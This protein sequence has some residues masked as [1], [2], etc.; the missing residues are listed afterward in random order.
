MITPPPG[1]VTI[2][3]PLARQVGYLAAHIEPLHAQNSLKVAAM[4][5]VD[6][7]L[8]GM[9]VIDD[10][11]Y[12]GFIMEADVTRALAVGMEETHPIR[13]LVIHKPAPLPARTPAAEALRIFAETKTEILAVVDTQDRVIG[14]LTP[15]RLISP[16]GH[17][18][19]PKRIGGL[20]TPIGVYLTDGSVSGGAPSYSLVLTGMA[21][22]G[23][24]TV[25]AYLAL[26]IG[27]LLP[28]EWQSHPLA[29][30]FVEGMGFVFFLL[31]IRSLPLAGYHAA[32]HMVVHAIEQGEPLE[33][34]AVRRMS[35]VHPRCG[36]NLAMA[37]MLFL[38]LFS[39]AWTTDTELRLLVAFLVTLVAYRPLGSFVQYWF[40][41][42][43]PNDK[44]LKSGIDAG[45][46]LLNNF[47][48]GGALQPN[49]LQRLLRT[50][51]FH[52]MAGST[53]AGIAVIAISEILKLPPDWQ[54]FSP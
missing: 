23:I 5:L 39:W 8:P 50:G 51:L 21:M 4:D 43:K 12:F 33:P 52:L 13:E 40:T 15:S 10:N 47:Q 19:K 35:R 22:F 20:A 29:G 1:S 44:Q 25:G 38:G 6:C 11:G 30:N 31:G 53:I 28:V 37:A 48:T 41:T 7:G 36:T 34:E 17:L 3:P 26:G 14:V 2:P 18:A 49:V 46:A 42:R 45:K 16:D 9:P 24:F 27:H 54:V 32:E